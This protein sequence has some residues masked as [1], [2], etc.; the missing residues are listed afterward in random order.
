MIAILQGSVKQDDDKVIH[1]MYDT[2]ARKVV[3]TV[4]R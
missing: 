3:G 2:E 4:V 1:Y